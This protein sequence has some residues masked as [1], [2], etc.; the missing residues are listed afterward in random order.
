[1]TTFN[2]WL[3]RKIFLGFMW[4]GLNTVSRATTFSWW[5][6]LGPTST[7]QPATTGNSHLLL[8]DSSEFIT[9]VCSC[10]YNWYM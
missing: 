4:K 5:K 9:D 6:R 8:V 10:L 2:F 1:M 3:T 7:K